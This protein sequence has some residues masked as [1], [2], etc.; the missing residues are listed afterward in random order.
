MTITKKDNFTFNS[1]VKYLRDYRDR[2]IENPIVNEEK[3]RYRTR[4]NHTNKKHCISAFDYY[5]ANK[6]KKM[7][8]A[9]KEIYGIADDEITKFSAQLADVG[10]ICWQ[11]L[12]L[13]HHVN[14]TISIDGCA[15]HDHAQLIVV[16]LDPSAGGSIQ[17][18]CRSC[19]IV[20]ALTQRVC[21]RHWDILWNACILAHEATRNY[22]NVGLLVT[23]VGERSG[24]VGHQID[25]S[26]TFPH[27]WTE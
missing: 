25:S 27:I 9:F 20:L 23:F 26:L 16:A 24:V 13:T 15:Q 4:D 1:F 22:F 17:R 7:L 6:N 11:A 8:V 12:H 10:N 18:C 5:L 14:A 3:T 21:V 2:V 19:K